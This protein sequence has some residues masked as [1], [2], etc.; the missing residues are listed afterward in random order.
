MIGER[1]LDVAKSRFVLD[2]HLRD[3]A[4]KERGPRIQPILSPAKEVDDPLSIWLIS[5][6]YLAVVDKEMCEHGLP[7]SRTTG[8]PE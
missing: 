7:F 8:D 4:S 2:E 3:K 5:S 6:H 1:F